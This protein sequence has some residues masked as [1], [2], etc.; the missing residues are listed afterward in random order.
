MSLTSLIV[1]ASEAHSKSAVNPY[2]IGGI[3]LSLL[4]AALITVVAIGGGR[5]H[6]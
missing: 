4:V 6:S 1:L 5:E 3:A 2:V